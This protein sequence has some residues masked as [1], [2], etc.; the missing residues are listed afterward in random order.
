M[1]IR[2]VPIGSAIIFLNVWLK[3]VRARG[4]VPLAHAIAYCTYRNVRKASGTEIPSADQA[5]P[6]NNARALGAKSVMMTGVFPHRTE[7][8]LAAAPLALW[9]GTYTGAPLDRVYAL[10][11]VSPA[12]WVL[13][14]IAGR[15]IAYL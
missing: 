4:S 3:P 5:N 1:S 7:E 8:I 15:S 12:G 14:L 2:A 13:V 10:A 9:R 6:A 11:A